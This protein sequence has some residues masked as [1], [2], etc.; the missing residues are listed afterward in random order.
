MTY[1]QKLDWDLL[2]V[3]LVRE[4][5][6]EEEH[7]VSDDLTS[8]SARRLP[9]EIGEL[10]LFGRQRELSDPPFSEV[11]AVVEHDCERVWV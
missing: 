4:G 6:V 2:L 11:R 5:S 8:R 10:V 9:A 7:G 3:R 1:L